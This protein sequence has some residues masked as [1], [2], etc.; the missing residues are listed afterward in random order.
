[1]DVV[2]LVNH[3]RQYPKHTD[4][5]IDQLWIDFYN[6]ISTEHGIILGAPHLFVQS[7]NK[8]MKYM[9]T[10]YNSIKN[11]NCN[12]I[13]AVLFNKIRLVALNYYV[14]IVNKK[15]LDLEFRYSKE[16]VNVSEI[17][18]EALTFMGLN[19]RFTRD[20]LLKRYRILVLK[21]HP[22]KGGRVEDFRKLQVYKEQLE[23]KFTS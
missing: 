22:D 6:K 14:F 4:Y 11:V 23:R 2:Y 7:V 13:W 19:D 16:K 12:Y 21:Y 5:V 15:F 8:T 9:D 18:N 17:T 20:D 3:L 10:I 1:M